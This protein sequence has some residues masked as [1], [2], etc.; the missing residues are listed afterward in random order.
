MLFIFDL[1]DS[2]AQYRLFTAVFGL[3]LKFNTLVVV[4]VDAEFSSDHARFSSLFFRLLFVVCDFL[5]L[6]TTLINI[7]AYISVFYRYSI[8]RTYIHI[9]AHVLLSARFYINF[10]LLVALC[11]CCPFPFV[12]VINWCCLCQIKIL[13]LQ[14]KIGFCIIEF[15]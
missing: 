10:R 6:P 9:S 13:F 2:L 3:N 8:A 14:K 1:L 15:S 11:L 12:V 7:F 4:K 5:Q